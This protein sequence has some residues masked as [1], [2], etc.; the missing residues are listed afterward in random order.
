MLSAQKSDRGQWGSMT[1]TIY[2]IRGERLSVVRSEKDQAD[3][4]VF[5]SLNSLLNLRNVV[6]DKLGEFFPNASPSKTP[7][8]VD[9]VHAC[10][11]G[12]HDD[13]YDDD[14]HA[15]ILGAHDDSYD[16]EVHAVLKLQIN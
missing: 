3:Q 10:I 13:S 16:N 2:C 9:D 4:P 6:P 5:P 8:R 1:W 12:A 7:A 15:C 11:L 14:V